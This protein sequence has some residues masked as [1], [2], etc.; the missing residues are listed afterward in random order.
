MMKRINKTTLEKFIHEELAALIESYSTQGQANSSIATA[1][2]RAIQDEKYSGTHGGSATAGTDSTEVS[3]TR[4][5]NLG[6]NTRLGDRTNL[7]LGSERGRVTDIGLQYG[8]KDL[9][10]GA[11]FN[12]ENLAGAAFMSYGKKG[13]PRFN[14]G[15]GANPNA[16]NLSTRLTGE[17]WN[18]S[19]GY[20]TDTGAHAGAEGTVGG[21][22]LGGGYQQ[23]GRGAGIGGRV[24]YGPVRVGAT[25]DPSTGDTSYTGG[26][27]LAKL[28]PENKLNQIIQEEYEK[29]LKEH[30]AEYVWGVKAPYHRAAN[31][32]ELSVLKHDLLN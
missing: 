2:N 26:V 10:L 12:P 9:N 7:R 17:N 21:V 6:I 13:S 14:V 15:L 1:A 16:L 22:T 11:E 20:G 18:F 32:Y 24:G 25:Y 3:A 30:A 28:M 19:G 31:Q 8:G 29:L 5:G 4:S 23:K 27:G